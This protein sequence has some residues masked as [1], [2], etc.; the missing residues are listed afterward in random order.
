VTWQIR[1]GT[2][3]DLTYLDHLSRR[4]SRQVGFLNR[5]AMRE[6]LELGHYTVLDLEGQPAA[7]TLTTG[8]IRKPVR[9]VQHAVDEEMWRQGW[10]LKLIEAAALK[11]T[12]CP[13]AGLNLTCRDGLPANAF[14]QAAGARLIDVRPGGRERRKMLLEWSFPLEVILDA[15]YEIAGS[16]HLDDSNLHQSS[17]RTPRPPLLPLR[18]G[19]SI[20]PRENAPNPPNPPNPQE[21]DP[22]GNVQVH[23]PRP[24]RGNTPRDALS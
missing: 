24:S 22:N 1:P 18:L 21:R 6:H 17:Y 20:T 11:A 3:R 4:F 5:T 23:F 9:I 2:A 8:G 19:S 14:W 12:R 16:H 10:G 13:Q 7:F 15:A